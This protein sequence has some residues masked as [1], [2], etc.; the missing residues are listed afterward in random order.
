M[1]PFMRSG[2]IFDVKKYA[3]NDGPGIRVAIF[4]KGCPL[5]CA[6]CHNPESISPGVQKMYNR[7]KCAGCKLCV[8]SCPQEACSFSLDGIITD[9]ERC[10]ICGSCAD[11]CPAK[12][13]KMTGRSVT[14][15]ELVET[16]EKERVF[17]DQS[18]GGVTFSGGEPLHQWQ[19][20][21]SLLDEFGRRS[22]H[23]A[24]DTTGFAQWQVLLEVAQ[25]TDLFL[26]DLKLMDCQRHKKWTGVE[27]SLILENLRLLAQAGSEINIRIPLIKGVNDDNENLEQTAVF[28]AGLAGKK[29]KVNILPYHKIA[30]HK[31]LKLGI[32]YDSS[33]MYEPDD[34]DKDRVVMLFDKHDIEVVIGG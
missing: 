14:V 3:I 6:W 23:R 31:Y 17:I 12:A 16:V 9:L 24:V 15:E 11:A 33:E 2:C 32:K 30:A 20:L 22:I 7:E 5:H 29:K 10:R 26:Y 18:N 25:R 19:F 27:N 28:V 13:N 34:D 8:E 4:F 1:V 21:V